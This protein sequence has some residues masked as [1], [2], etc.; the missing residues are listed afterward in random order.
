MTSK[1]SGFRAQALEGFGFSGVSET[2]T[3]LLAFS[4]GSGTLGA[5]ASLLCSAFS[6]D[7]TVRDGQPSR[8]KCSFP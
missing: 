7:G 8:C 3:D 6:T 1:D 2:S 5:A 4:V